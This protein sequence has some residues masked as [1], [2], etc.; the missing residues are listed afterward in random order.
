MKDLTRLAI[1]TLRKKGASYGDARYVDREDEHIVVKSKEVDQLVRSRSKG[2]GVRAI[3]DGSWGFAATSTLTPAEVERVAAE[4]VEVAR[5]SASAQKE[6]VKLAD[7]PAHKDTYTTP[8]AKDPFTVPLATKID[9]LTKCCDILDRDPKIKV[10]EA[11]YAAWRVNKQFASTEGADIEQ[12]ITCTGGGF[13]ATALGAND[14]QRRSY[15]NSFRGNYATAGWEYVDGLHLL[16]HAEQVR[17]DAV[18]LLDAPDCPDGEWD[19]ILLGS[20]LA[21]QIHESCGHPVELDRVFGTELSLAGGSF[22][23]PEL[24]GNFTYGSKLVNITADSTRAGGLGTFGYDDEGV[25]STSTPIIQEGRFVG[26]L[27]SRETAAKIRKRSNGAMRADGWN[28]IPLIRMINVSLEAG[29]W[30]LDDLIKDTKR[31]LLIDMNKSWSIDDKR[32]N[33]QFGCE[34]AREIT[35]GE[36]GRIYK[37]PLYSGMTPQFWGSCDAVCGPSEWQ[38]WGTPNCG[39]GVPGQTMHVGHGAAPARFRKVKVGRSK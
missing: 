23:Q 20:Q 27:M 3:V 9:L 30:K 33:F 21:L 26:Y 39:K 16:D 4:A 36:L 6:R 5:A 24:L 7:E 10:S 38:L 17:K 12:T 8:V 22:L 1:D 37:N 28:R 25:K 11:S 19:L 2:I 18:E 15:P 34:Y 29:T 31:G 32:V 13:T 14:M 35:D